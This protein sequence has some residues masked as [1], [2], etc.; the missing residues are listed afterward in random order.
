MFSNLTGLEIVFF[1]VALLISMVV[2]EVMHGVMAKSLGDSTASDLGRLTL[3]PLKHIDVLTTL[4]LPLVLVL[5]GLPPIFAAKPVPFNPNNVKYEEYGVALV[6]LAGP[7]TNLVLAIIGAL[8]LHFLSSLSISF[9]QF[10]LIFIEINVALMVFNLIPFPPLDGSRILYAFAPEP[11]Q[12]LMAKIESMGFM[13]VLLFIFF[14]FQFVGPIIQ[15]VE[16]TIFTV[17]LHI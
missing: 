15:S 17:L 12:E 14:I 4:L 10:L 8:L 11:L 13:V 5:F 2:H 1:I 9:D 3:N 7:L 6:G 16:S